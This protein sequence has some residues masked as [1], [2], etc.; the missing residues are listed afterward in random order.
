M[1][2]AGVQAGGGL[3]LNAIRAELL[4]AVREQCSA[5]QAS[6]A[7]DLV[8]DVLL[9]L[10]ERVRQGE[11]SAV[12]HASY[13]R[14]AAYHAL[15]D[16]L[17]RQR[18][19]RETP[20]EEAGV[21]Q[22]AAGSPVLDPGRRAASRELGSAIRDCLLGLA[23]GRRIPVFLHLQGHSVPEASALLGWAAKRT[24]SALFRGLRDLRAC[25][26]G[27]GFAP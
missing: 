14:R 13:W 12:R 10:V 23:E 2:G 24:A 7:E 8:H 16:E 18:R 19:R 26:A 4:R 5:A 20:L 15:V 1:P 11:S 9:R 25:L 21:E 3:D 22:F 27:K 17:R 6:R